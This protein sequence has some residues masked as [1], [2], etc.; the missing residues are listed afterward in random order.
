[1]RLTGLSTYISNFTEEGIIAPITFDARQTS[2]MVASTEIRIDR[3][4]AS[5]TAHGLVGVQAVVKSS[6]NEVTG[7]LANN[8]SLA[9]TTNVGAPQ[10]NGI[11]MGAGLN[12][13][14]TK[15]VGM[16]LDYRATLASDTQHK[17][18]GGVKLAF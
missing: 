7:N 2:L 18:N 11:Y 17:L 9:Q 15:T 13:M 12:K 16:G 4:I 10:I 3:N 6:G 14:F 1:M 8:S 5:L